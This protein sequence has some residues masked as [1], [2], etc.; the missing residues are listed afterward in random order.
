MFARPAHSEKKSEKPFRVGGAAFLY[1]KENI[2]TASP[3]PNSNGQVIR[4]PKGTKVQLIAVAST[5]VN[6]GIPL[7]AENALYTVQFVKEFPIPTQVQGVARHDEVEVIGARLPKGKKLE[8]GTN[9]RLL[10]PVSI[11]H[12]G[13]AYWVPTGSTIVV[14]DRTARQSAVRVGQ[15]HPVSGSDVAY[16]FSWVIDVPTPYTILLDGLKHNQL[17]QTPV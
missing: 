16:K 3:V 12:I 11:E 1:L 6:T 4:C 2:N 9:A 8:R 13:R 10:V 5:G 7:K 17:S 14:G 15:P